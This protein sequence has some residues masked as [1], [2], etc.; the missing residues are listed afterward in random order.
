MTTEKQKYIHCDE[1]GNITIL[2]EDDLPKCPK[3]NDISPRVIII[4]MSERFKV[5]EVEVLTPEDIKAG[6][7]EGTIWPAV[8]DPKETVT[9]EC[10]NED[11]AK[12]LCEFLNQQE[13][14]IA[15]QAKVNAQ[16]EKEYQE[17]YSKYKHETERLIEI[18]NSL[19]MQIEEMKKE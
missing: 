5:E 12:E 2:S 1:N 7:D 19:K 3:T 14:R 4:C 18:N 9:Y 10:R 15:L 6:K 8:T 11:V 13:K 16:Q 17:L